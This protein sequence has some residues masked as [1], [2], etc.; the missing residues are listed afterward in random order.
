M[1]ICEQSG[2]PA[3]QDIALHFE[4]AWT[5]VSAAQ[6]HPL[7]KEEYARVRAGKAK[8]EMDTTRYRLDPPPL[9]RR[10]DMSH[11]APRWRTRTASSSTN[12]TGAP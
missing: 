8:Q 4:P 11:G 9:N 10:N 3:K 5:R 2:S 12:T 7:L 1:H 6:E